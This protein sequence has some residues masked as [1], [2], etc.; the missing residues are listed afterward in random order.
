MKK[1]LLPLLFLFPLASYADSPKFDATKFAV[2]DTLKCAH[3]TVHADTAKSELV[4]NPTQ[5]GDKETARVRVFY[6][7]LF[8]SDAMTI[9]Y[10]LIHASI[11]FI[12]AEVLEDTSTTKPCAYF[13][14]WQE[15]KGH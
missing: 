11:T 7:G 15:L 3:P 9:E 2:E 8:K 6:K 10:T 12:H 5:M 1:A 4:G 14:G 13:N